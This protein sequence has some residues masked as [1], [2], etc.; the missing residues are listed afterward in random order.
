VSRRFGRPRTG[1]CPALERL[2]LGRL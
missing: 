2:R 1:Q